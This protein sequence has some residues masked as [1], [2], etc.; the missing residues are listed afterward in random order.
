MNWLAVGVVPM[1]TSVRRRERCDRVQLAHPRGDPK[2]PRGAGWYQA[3]RPAD[4]EGAVAEILEVRE[5]IGRR[6]FQLYRIVR[7]ELLSFDKPPV[8]RRVS[9]MLSVW[10]AS[11]RFQAGIVAAK[12][13]IV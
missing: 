1:E 7:D 6:F 10:D 3:H 11:S 4:R 2:E 12:R 9:R 13:G 5:E 8:S